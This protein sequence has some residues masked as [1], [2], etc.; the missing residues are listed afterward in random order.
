MIGL[1]GHQIGARQQGI[2]GGQ[3]R[4]A[5]GGQTTATRQVN[6]VTDLQAAGGQL[7]RIDRRAGGRVIGDDREGSLV[8]LAA[9]VEYVEGTAQTGN[10]LVGK[11][12][13][14]ALG[15]DPGAVGD[16]DTVA[17]EV[18]AFGR[19]RGQHQVLL[20][21]GIDPVQ[22]ALHPPERNQGALGRIGGDAA[23]S[24][25]QR[26]PGL[27]I[28]LPQGRQQRAGLNDVRRFQR[29]LAAGRQR[30]RAGGIG[31]RRPGHRQGG[32]GITLNGHAKIGEGRRI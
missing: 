11:K 9:R 25:I 32:V 8:A 23:S 2:V 13:A 26:L 29:Q 14:A 21:Q 4:I 31:G 24:Q 5:A 15:V 19:R 7:K 20:A 30:G 17:V 6:A 10:V 28:D 16:G 27:E 22:S 3:Q 12:I 18:D 1:R